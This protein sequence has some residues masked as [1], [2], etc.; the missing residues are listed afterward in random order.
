MPTVQRTLFDM[1]DEIEQ[2]CGWLPKEE[3]RTLALQRGMPLY[4]LQEVASF[5]N[6]YHLE[7][8]ADVEVR[9]CRD[10]A[11]HM[12]GSAQL[13]G[14]VERHFGDDES[15]VK[16]VGA[17]CLGRCDQP[18]AF[19]I[20]H[21]FYQATNPDQCISNIEAALKGNAEQDDLYEGPIPPEWKIDPYQGEETYEALKDFISNKDDLS[22]QQELV[23][24]SLEESKLVG[25]G[26]P[27]ART[28]KKWR[29]VGSQKQDVRYV[30]C[31]GD[32][33]E[34]GTFKDRE[35][36]SKAPHL[37]IE[38]VLIAGLTL[39]ARECWI[40]VRHE[41]PQQIETLRKAITRARE[42]GVCGRNI[43]GSR[44]D[45]DIDVF[46][47]P[48][49]YICGEQTALIEAMEL[50]RPEP[51]QRPPNLEIK[52]LFQKP[53]LVNNVETFA[54]IPAILRKGPQWYLDQGANGCTGRRFI[55]VS[56]DVEK[57]GVH[58]VPLGCTVGDMLEL[59]GGIAG[60]RAMQAVGLSGPS[61]GFLPPRLSRRVLPSGFQ[62]KYMSK[63]EDHFDI[64][65]LP[66]DNNFFRRTLEGRFAVGAAIIF[67]GEQTDMYSLIKN[68][69]EFY[70][71]ESCG[72]CVPCRV[73]GQKLVEISDGIREGKAPDSNLFEAL[74]Q[75]M[76][77][78]S[79][80]GLG[81]VAS[82]PI[83]SFLEFFPE[84]TSEDG[85]KDMMMRT[86]QPRDL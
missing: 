51:R 65:K 5:Y 75:T 27:G 24:K 6:S 66:V 81:Q 32:E 60:G 42:M 37:V 62:D 70:R 15:R 71:N 78:A 18:V 28:G 39:G 21:H 41:Y 48:G 22:G 36:F 44:L 12:R 52:G 30:V 86:V 67:V 33:S 69:T 55:S 7:K 29:T 58:E 49:N 38:G 56:G 63:D 76:R 46:V 25:K 11:C 16:V 26:G 77:E 72:K 19:G 9:V 47:S 45:C 85:A 31:N 80:C 43:L 82:V 35:L 13:R 34:P 23:L 64:L 68:A 59:C 74:Q 84:Y 8:P 3:L 4:R 17:S 14:A 20:G 79:I 83:A 61:G 73:G 1:L 2:R 40:Y 57:P 53:T 10:M 50:K 54:W